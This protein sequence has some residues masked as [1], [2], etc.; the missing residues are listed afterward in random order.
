VQFTLCELQ[1]GVLAGMFISSEWH[2]H[3]GVYCCFDALSRMDIRCY[4][5]CSLS[6][7][8][9]VQAAAVDSLGNRYAY[10]FFRT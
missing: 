2:V 5:D 10:P 8:Q 6:K 4:I 7:Q 1:A 9:Q 3:S